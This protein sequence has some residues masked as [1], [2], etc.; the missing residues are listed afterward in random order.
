SEG[1]SW[2]LALVL[3]DLLRHRHDGL[4][5]CYPGERSAG[6][7]AGVLVLLGIFYE[8]EQRLKALH[9]TPLAE[10]IRR[11]FA[12]RIQRHAEDSKATLI[13]RLIRDAQVV[14][15]LLEHVGKD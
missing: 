11:T 1:V 10:S 15:L 2:F 3:A 4:L 9:V 7:F 5:I 8:R 6:T 14:G 12:E 13:H